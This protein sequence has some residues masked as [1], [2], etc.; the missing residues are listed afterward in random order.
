[1]VERVICWQTLADIILWSMAYG[2]QHVSLYDR[3]G[4]VRAG[5]ETQLRPQLERRRRA[6]FGSTR[7]SVTFLDGGAGTEPIANGSAA[8]GDGDR[9]RVSVAPLWE[10]DGVGDMVAAARRLCSEVAAGAR[11]AD[12]IDRHMFGDELRAARRWPDPALALKLGPVRALLGYLPWQLR[13]TEVLDAPSR[14]PLA[15]EDYRRLLTTYGGIQ[16]RM[17]S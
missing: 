12:S 16:Q 14:R 17:G 11:Q 1:M 10:P 2:I 3:N 13:L 8:V 4:W 6:L 15:Y 5:A 9:Y 7:A